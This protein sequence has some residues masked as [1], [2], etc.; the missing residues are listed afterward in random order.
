[1]L[2]V[3]A[4]YERIGRIYVTWLELFTRDGTSYSSVY[5]HYPA[6]WKTVWTLHLNGTG[7][8]DLVA[9]DSNRY[10]SMT[11][12]F[13]ANRC[14]SRAQGHGNVIQYILP[15]LNDFDSRCGGSRG[16]NELKTLCH[17][18]PGWLNYSTDPD[19]LILQASL[20]YTIVTGII[21]MYTPLN[22]DDWN[23]RTLTCTC[24][25][26]HLKIVQLPCSFYEIIIE[27]RFITKSRKSLRLI[28]R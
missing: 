23:L 24:C 16:G 6:F 22:L 1:M 4:C 19:P 14:H 9:T 15:D 12:L 20:W 27:I 18:R 7:N 17:P 5:T 21:K 8:I 28:W 25:L 11:Y 13:F 3:P 2:K 10:L 26:I